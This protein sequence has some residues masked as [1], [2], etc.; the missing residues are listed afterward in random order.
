M[1]R[2]IALLRGINVGGHRKVPMTELRALAAGIG[3]RNVETYIQSGNL[4]FAAA[5]DAHVL[6][7]KLERAIERRF[8]FAIDVVVRSAVQW[9]RLTAGNPFRVEMEK[10]PD[11]VMLLL[12]KRSPVAGGVAA[13]AQ[14]A[15]AGEQV[16]AV[17]EAVWIHCPEGMGRSKLTP[18]LLDR[19]L[20]SPATARNWR[21]VVALKEMAETER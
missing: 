3:W 4:V 9:A 2:W 12:T 6:A 14:R 8:G 21:T 18:A 19:L 1:A 7:A 5:G 16:A 20:G 11:R 17:G 10:A 13:L 15:A